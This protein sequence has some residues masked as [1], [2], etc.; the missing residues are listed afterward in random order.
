MKKRAFSRRLAACS[1]WAL[2]LIVAKSHSQVIYTDNFDAGT[3][4][5]NWA[6]TQSASDSFV[7]FA[8]DYS[9][10]GIPSANGAGRTTTGVRFL[11]NQTAVVQQGV[12]ASPNGQSF[13]G[14]F[15]INFSAWLNYNGPLGPTTV[16]GSGS[17]QVGSFGWGSNGTSVQWAGASSSTMFGTTGDGGST[18]DYRVYQNNALLSP[19]VGSGVGVYA[20]GNLASSYNNTDPYYS[21]FGG[22]SAPAAQVALYSGQ[23]GTTPA[24]APAFAWRNMELIKVGS[25]FSWFMDGTRIATAS[26]TGATLSGNNIFL[27]T[28]DINNTSSTDPNDFLIAAI[29]DNVVVTQIPEPTAFTLAGLAGWALT[30]RRRAVS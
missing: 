10:L 27:G 12:S 24:G 9:T 5:A 6:A 2:L 13:T 17:T 30:R 28:F 7:N 22:A 25:S 23:T 4:A 8:F 1:G 21:G 26:L 11:T 20:A 15:K 19:N 14:D 16:G 29:Y 3:S 18:I